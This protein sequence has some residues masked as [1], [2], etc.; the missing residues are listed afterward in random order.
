MH[1]GDFSF[2]LY[3]FC[4]NP[5]KLKC[6][7]RDMGRFR[8]REEEIRTLVVSFVV[9]AFSDSG[10]DV[11]KPWRATVLLKHTAGFYLPEPW[12]GPGELAFPVSSQ[13]LSIPSYT[14]GITPQTRTYS[15]SLF[16]RASE[17]FLVPQPSWSPSLRS[18]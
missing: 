10:S 6:T 11:L 17:L 8:A 4:H 16:I 1:I 14:L 12:M 15:S 5:R 18:F 7:K 2:V 13:L 9:L 3:L